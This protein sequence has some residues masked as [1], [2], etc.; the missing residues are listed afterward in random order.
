MTIR[1]IA[2]NRPA[3]SRYAV[4]F[5]CDAKYLPYAALA[6]HTLVR[7]NPVRDFDI[8]ITSLD[9]L[10][11]PPAL[12][13]HDVRLCQIDVGDAFA[14]FPVSER[15]SVAAYLRLTLPHAFTT[16]YSR[17]LYLDSDVFVVGDALKA[18]FSIDLQGRP[19]GA[20]TDSTKWKHPG[21]ATQDQKVL[22]I[23]GP[24]FN[25]GMLLIDVKEY[26]SKDVLTVCRSILETYGPEK[27]FF[28]Q[29]LLNLALAENWAELHPAWNWQWPVVRPLFEIFIDVQIVHFITNT[30]PWSDPR[31]SLPI[32]YREQARRFFEEHFPQIATKTA[33]PSAQLKKRKVL[34][35]LIKH[36]T[37][38]FTFVDGY[39]RHGGDIM[40]VV[41]PD[42]P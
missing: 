29:M 2:E 13:G 38:S 12:E 9:A 40:K 37:R 32:K 31:G 16:D 25:S 23:N 6:I 39:N 22:S 42:R 27:I 34:F 21:K 15:F 5:C 4:V 17:I 24:Y 8:C 10:E 41:L 14:G 30:K 33:P 3:A 28:D 26:E 36:I 1:V 18:I 35:R 11:L 20:C 19:V 7:N